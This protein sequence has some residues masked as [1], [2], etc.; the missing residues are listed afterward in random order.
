MLFV[1]LFVPVWL[2]VRKEKGGVLVGSRRNRLNPA[3]TPNPKPRVLKGFT[4]LNKPIM[5]PIYASWSKLERSGLR[6][7]IWMQSPSFNKTPFQ[8]PHK[9][10]RPSQFER[11][12]VHARADGSALRTQLLQQSQ[13]PKHTQPRHSSPATHRHPSML[14][15]TVLKASSTGRLSSDL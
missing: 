7:D 8:M 2:L 5:E 9:E 15:L 13:R 6:A 10:R 1:C 14:P 3:A 11:Q 4:G 12:P